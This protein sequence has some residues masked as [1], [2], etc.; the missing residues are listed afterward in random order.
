[1]F[2]FKFWFMSVL[3]DGAAS[4]GPLCFF[5]G[6]STHVRFCRSTKLWET[7]LEE[8]KWTRFCVT[9]DLTS[10]GTGRKKKR[11]DEYSCFVEVFPLS[12][13]DVTEFGSV[14][15]SRLDDGFYRWGAWS[16]V[17][18]TFLRRLRGIVWYAQRWKSIVRQRHN[19]FQGNLLTFHHRLHILHMYMYTYT[20]WI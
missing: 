11:K 10:A 6:C 5:G 4:L 17:P 12:L 7:F 13:V 20:V 16:G 15:I 2:F 8:L 3:P 14:L 1:M 9:R 19:Y 18:K